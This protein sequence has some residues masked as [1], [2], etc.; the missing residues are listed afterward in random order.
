MKFATLIVSAALIPAFAQ[1]DATKESPGNQ[2]IEFGHQFFKSHR[3]KP[4]KHWVDKYRDSNSGETDEVHTEFHAGVRFRYIRSKSYKGDELSQVVFT[5]PI[6]RLP[7]G[8]QLGDS[9]EKI[10]KLLGEPTD[11]KPELFLYE[12]GGPA[13]ADILQFR[14]SYERL[15]EFEIGYEHD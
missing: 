2:L 7:F 3:T 1:V 10:K 8:I 11:S 6:F 5:A 13:L 14:F 9:P 12:V 4:L 15:I